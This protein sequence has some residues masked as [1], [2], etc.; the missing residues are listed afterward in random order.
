MSESGVRLWQSGRVKISDC[1]KN[2]AFVLTSRLSFFLSLS[3]LAVQLALIAAYLA[4]E[5]TVHF[6][7]YAMYAR[8][9]QEWFA[10]SGLTLKLR[11]FFDSFAHNYNLLFA[12]PSSLFFSIFGASRNVF[13]LANVVVFLVPAQAGLGLVAR[14]VFGWSFLQGFL[15]AQ[16]LSFLIPALWI[17]LVQGYP[18]L[19]AAACL[20]AAFYL[21]L[22][23]RRGWRARVSLGVAL[24][25]AVVFR[26]H[27]AYPALALACAECCLGCLRA[28]TGAQSLRRS[29]V[30][31]GTTGLAALV[32]LG[33]VEPLYLKEMLSTNF[34]ALYASYTYTPS[35]YLVYLLSR[36]GVL[37]GLVTIV[38]LAVLWKKTP[39]ARGA[40]SLGVLFFFFWLM[41]WLFGPA[42]KGDHYLAGVLPLPCFLG[43]LGW[44][45]APKRVS[46]FV[47]LALVTQTAFIFWPHTTFV[48]PSDTPRISLFATPR[49]P[50]RRSDMEALAALAR[51]IAQTTTAND[52]ILV[53]GSS[54]VF[55]QDLVRAVFTDLIN[56]V[57]TPQRFI[58][59]PE[60]DGLLV[61]PHDAFASANV[62]LVPN[63]PQYH[64][65]PKG[66]KVITTL[67][68]A[69]SEPL[70]FFEKDPV[71]FSLERDV[72]VSIW[73]R[74]P[75][76]GRMLYERLSLMDDPQHARWLVVQGYPF[77]FVAHEKNKPLF[78][79]TLA[80][81]TAKLSFFY[82]AP[83][84]T[85][86][87]RFGFSFAHLPTCAGARILGELVSPDGIVLEKTEGIP[88]Q[89]PGLYY[90]AFSIAPQHDKKS[91]LFLSFLGQGKEKCPFVVSDLVF[92][93]GPL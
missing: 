41:A 48:L 53:A 66:Q 40:V 80:N 51:H 90:W 25:M 47:C 12:V 42:Q 85:G 71:S 69:F 58:P 89:N 17:P 59:I 4:Q 50:W 92:E 20:H 82:N 10:L 65:D 28:F 67:F 64:L 26:R 91:F 8:L 34:T 5:N 43:L 78:T 52:K 45:R 93:R 79:G 36:F 61:R 1:L 60:T 88:L 15:A 38:G 86:F 55:N 44:L 18:D 31:C 32:V 22:D 27:F 21:A 57:E 75:W 70:A 35:E 19:A 49:A 54:F 68:S 7:D 29:V 84:T 3:L 62:Y 81:K 56:D 30:A 2:K 63:A 14:R 83:L 74:R 37:S 6:W 76:T 24:A 13:V 46:A 11:V 23:E 72:V 16:C 73:R 77:G 39:A 87:Y 9:A 33:G